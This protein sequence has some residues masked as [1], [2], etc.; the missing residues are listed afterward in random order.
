MNWFQKLRRKIEYKKSVSSFVVIVNNGDALSFGCLDDAI[1]YVKAY[2][3]QFNIV[4]NLI[5]FKQTLTPIK[6]E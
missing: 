5:I 2:R 4:N 3:E 6:Y 1:N